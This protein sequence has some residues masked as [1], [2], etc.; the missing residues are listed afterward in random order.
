M[1]KRENLEGMEGR[2]GDLEAINGHLRV[3]RH[4]HHLARW[5]FDLEN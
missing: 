1:K 2:K 5:E 3:R 4:R